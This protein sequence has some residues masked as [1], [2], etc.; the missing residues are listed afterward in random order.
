M[1]IVTVFVIDIGTGWLRGR[2]VRQGSRRHDQIIDAGRGRPARALSRMYFDRPASARLALPR[3]ITRRHRV[4]CVRPGSP[5]IFTGAD[6]ERGASARLDHVD[7]VAARSRLIIAALSQC[8]RRNAFDR[9][10]WHHAGRSLCAA[11][12]PAG[13]KKHRAL[14]YCPR[15][16]SAASSTRSAASIP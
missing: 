14:E 7:D 11:V 1:I 13:G 15:F 10:A 16:L 8:T 3:V 4:V 12:Q 5:R 6:A 2:L 9:V